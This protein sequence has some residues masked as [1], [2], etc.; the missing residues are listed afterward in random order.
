[1]V[2]NYALLRSLFLF[3]NRGKT[4]PILKIMKCVDILSYPNLLIILVCMIRAFSPKIIVFFIS[5]FFSFVSFFV[6]L[7]PVSGEY[8][9]E[10]KQCYHQLLSENIYHIVTVLIFLK[11]FQSAF[12]FHSSKCLRNSDADL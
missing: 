5:F 8:F 12:K 2:L 6:S 3:F 7:H 4:L 9:P 11:I 10:Q 1:M